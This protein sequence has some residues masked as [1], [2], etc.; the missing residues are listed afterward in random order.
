MADD[1]YNNTKQEKKEIYN[2]DNILKEHNQERKNSQSFYERL[3]SRNNSKRHSIDEIPSI[4]Y[5]NDQKLAQAGVDLKKFGIDIDKLEDGLTKKYLVGVYNLVYGDPEKRSKNDSK[6]LENFLEK[7][8][9]LD[10]TI[11]IDLYGRKSSGESVENKGL[12][13][14]LN[15]IETII[16]EMETGA[17]TYDSQCS[18]TTQRMKDTEEELN[19]TNDRTQR[20]KLRGAI[21]TFRLNKKEDEK[22]KRKILRGITRTHHEYQQINKKIEMLEQVSTFVE[23]FIDEVENRKDQY[24]FTNEVGEYNKILTTAIPNIQETLSRMYVLGKAFDE[25]NYKQMQAT[26]E[27]TSSNIKIPPLENEEKPSPFTEILQNKEDENEKLMER[28]RQRSKG[29]EIKLFD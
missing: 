9:T 8:D 13:G 20:S 1:V 11:N 10:Q 22:A 23:N 27:L 26:A 6:R 4:M 3:F 29:E 25:H 7:V 2:I 14:Q 28:I 12:Y 17:L 16:E 15:E 21:S 19:K 18:H 24:A 5:T